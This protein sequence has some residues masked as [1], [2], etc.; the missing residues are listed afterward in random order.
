MLINNANALNTN[1]SSYKTKRHYGQNYSS[2]MIKSAIIYNHQLDGINFKGTTMPQ[3]N[4]QEKNKI[5]TQK[6]DEVFESEDGNAFLK[7][8]NEKTRLKPLFSPTLITYTSKIEISH[9]PNNKKFPTKEITLGTKTKPGNTIIV[10]D[11]TG[12]IQI[13]HS[14]LGHLFIDTAE[15][16]STTKMSTVDKSIIAKGL[17]GFDPFD[18]DDWPKAIGRKWP[19]AEN[20][21]DVNGVAKL[22]IDKS[23]KAVLLDTYPE[24][25]SSYGT[26]PRAIAVLD[27]KNDSVIV[28]FQ[29]ENQNPNI[30]FAAWSILPFKIKEGKKTLAIFPADPK[31]TE[32]YKDEQ[33]DVFRKIRKST[34]WN[35]DNKFFTVNLSNPS[36]QTEYIDPYADWC[37]FATQDDDTIC[38]L[39]SCYKDDT[40]GKQFKVFSGEKDLGGT[41]YAEVEFIAPKVPKNQK[42]TLV[43]RIDFIPLKKLGIESLTAE[44]MDEEM[45][46]IGE[47]IETRIAQTISPEENP[48]KSQL[49][50]WIPSWPFNKK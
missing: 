50:S 23:K 3:Q 28:A 37:V 29:Q 14:R 19:T 21:R 16:E 36:E 42:S 24:I 43:Y 46:K 6:F 31:S 26:K 13:D 22:S 38:L 20:T 17:R 33:N 27:G 10:A 8:V 35:I 18:Q 40:G 9:D 39:R 7:F 34:Q 5:W 32:A 47:R 49:T 12:H 25:A 41:K 45:K 15:L 44:N 4:N 48:E 11:R 30:D 1:I 2:Y